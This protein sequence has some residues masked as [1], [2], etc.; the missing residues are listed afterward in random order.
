MARR[1]HVS[2]NP[3]LIKGVERFSRSSSYKKKGKWA[4][5][6][7]KPVA[8]PKVEKKP[9]VKP[10]GKKGEKR[11]IAKKSPRFYPTE[12]VRKPLPSSKHNHRPT[13][14]R[15]T[16]KPGTVLIVLS[17][18]FRGKRVVF[19]KQLP[20]GLLLITG[21]FKLNGVPVRRMN[22]AYV[23]ATSTRVDLGDLKVDPKFDDAYFKKPKTKTK[24]KASSSKLFTQ[25]KEKKQIDPTRKTD[26]K[27]FDKS[28]LEVIAKQPHLVDYLGSRFS[29]KKGQFPHELKF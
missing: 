9:K 13:R 11:T 25:E 10:F 3:F 4:V 5:K 7:K 14:L 27:A 17:G 19:V 28:I 21:P 15:S 20:S 29:L 26:Q 16:I 12:R 23:I 6:N 1:P 2:R 24:E 18:R 8:A 22:Q